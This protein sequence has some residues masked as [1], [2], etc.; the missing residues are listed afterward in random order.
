ML[1][2][3][4]DIRTVTIIAI[5][6]A[7]IESLTMLFVWSTR[8]TYPG[9]G[10]WTA[11]SATF[12]VAFT[13]LSLRGLIPDFFSMVV[14]NALIVTAVALIHEGV[15]RFREF[16]SHKYV[17]VALVALMA[18][19]LF[20]FRFIDNNIW[21]RIIIASGLLAI[22]F[23][24]LSLALFYNIP[25]AQRATYGLAGG[26]FGSYA[27]FML[28][29]GVVVAMMPPTQ[30]M[31]APS[32]IQALTFALPIFLSM[33]WTFCFL[34]L[35]SERLEVELRQEVADRLAAETAL[36]K[37]NDQV[38]L[39]LDSTAEAIYGIDLEGRCT[40]ANPSCLRMLGYNLPEDIHGRNMHALIHHALPD[41][42]PIPQEACR[43]CAV[44]RDGREVHSEDEFFWRSDGVAFP[45]EYWAYPQTVGGVPTGV[46]VTFLD[47]TERKSAEQ[48][49]LQGKELAEAAAR[50]KSEFLASMSHE[51]RTPM[52]AIIGMAD[53]LLNTPLT[54]EQ[55]RYVEVFR[56]AGENLLYVINSILDLS[57]LDAGQMEVEAIPFS[58]TELLSG[59]LNMLSFKASQKGID[60]SFTV[61]PG[62]A[63]RYVGDPNK[64]RQILL[65]LVGNS[66]KFTP[67]GHVRI[68]VTLETSPADPGGRPPDEDCLVFQVADTGI[69][70]PPDMTETI[71]DKFMQADASMTRKFGGTGLGLAICRQ[72]VTLMGGRIWVES[73]EGMGSLFSFTVCL[74]RSEQPE[75]EPLETRNGRTETALSEMRPLSILLVEDNEDNILLLLSYLKGTPHSVDVAR[76]GQEAVEKVRASKGYDLILMDIQMPVMDGYT[77]TAH[78]RAEER[79]H[80]RVPSVIFALTAHA[81][82]GDDQ[83]SLDAGC[84][85]HL[86]KPI[87][88]RDFL[89]FLQTLTRQ[90]SLPRSGIGPSA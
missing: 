32:I 54:E 2:S 17:C 71:F 43:I 60:L 49:I 73:T 29:R 83:R 63:P 39:L 6:I 79:S 28:I 15:L 25:H 44:L 88:K 70:I 61:D 13:M 16:R 68:A 58:P 67:K 66:V 36:K 33:G 11:G 89:T 21:I 3:L 7:A 65:N 53:L 74:K 40:F 90:A 56:K 78:I 77:A 22:I 82:K 59:V 9:F 64:L 72:L 38:R 4:I 84:D 86:T 47:I 34:I 41:G 52:T 20:Y 57:K 48:Q 5:A 69:G 1:A 10:L 46:V 76:N 31:F 26:I 80:G 51:I 12:A 19:L 87:K 50:A 30:D 27:L 18:V 24:L 14:A 37:S 85:G 42:T 35:N 81:L 23:G 8:R 75:S 55:V 45:V 62:L